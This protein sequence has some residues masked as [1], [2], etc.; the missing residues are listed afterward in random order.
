MSNKSQDLLFELLLVSMGARK[1]LQQTYTDDDWKGALDMAKAHTIEAVLLSAMDTLDVHP[2]ESLL[3][4]WVVR[5]LLVEQGSKKKIKAAAALVKLFREH[6]FA[7]QIL[8]GSAVARY[9][10]QPLRRS[11]GDIDI[12]V[13]GGRKKICDF[14]RTLDKDGKLY[15]LNNHHIHLH[16]IPKVHI[17]VHFWPSFL[18]SPLHNWRFH[19]FCKLHWPTMESDMPSLAFDRVF[20]LHHCFRHICGYGVWLRQI[21]D[22]YY[23][24][25]QGFTEEERKDAVH[26]IKQLGMARFAR[27][28]M[29]VL[30]EY[31]GLEEPYLLMAP[32]EKEGRF[33]M[34]EVLQ[35]ND[36]RYIHTHKGDTLRTPLSRFFLYLKRDFYI[37][38]HYPQESLWRPMASAG[39][40]FWRLILK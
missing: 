30:Q 7:C 36:M 34:H 40:Q 14:A 2:P 35:T 13:D 12:W 4:Q 28:L 27:G 31:F 10:P 25:K 9:Y 24:L 33:I 21:M 38:K 5:S 32:D 19:R 26:W 16:I 23:V 8:K 15:G 39:K 17:E 20:I 1:S 18:S 29:W 11:S 6:G 22:Y 37:A 3:K